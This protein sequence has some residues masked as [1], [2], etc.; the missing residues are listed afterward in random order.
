MSEVDAKKLGKRADHATTCLLVMA[1]M[2]SMR[3]FTAMVSFRLAHGAVQFGNVCIVVSTVLVTIG[4]WLLYVGAKRGNPTAVAFVLAS[5]LATVGNALIGHRTETVGG[6]INTLTLIVILGYCAIAAL[7]EMGRR[8]TLRLQRE[9]LH[10]LV[11]GSPRPSRLFCMVGGACLLLGTVLWLSPA[12]RGAVLATSRAKTERLRADR[13][14][15]MIK[16]EEAAFVRRMA[17]AAKDP[18][19]ANAQ[20]AKV[21]LQA[22]T[23][24]AGRIGR[25]VKPEQKLGQVLADYGMATTHWGQALDLL[26]SPEPDLDGAQELLDQADQCRARAIDAYVQFFVVQKAENE[27]VSP[28]GPAAR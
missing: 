3:S 2:G 11:F 6:G 12:T 5:L 22:L 17:A 19:A 26:G 24:K 28:A 21:A 13:F 18:N 20:A 15:A 8:A 10:G 14:S 7:L 23:E 27:A 25:H 16:E 9:G 4:F 1:L